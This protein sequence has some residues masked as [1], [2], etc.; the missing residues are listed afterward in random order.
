MLRYLRQLF[1]HSAVYGLSGVAGRFVALLVLPI[2]T[3]VLS[4]ADYGTIDILTTVGAFFGTVM[5][6]GMNASL[7]NF[8]YDSED[9]GFRKSV[10]TTNFVFVCA[11]GLALVLAALTFGRTIFPYVL[12]MELPYLWIVFALL[13]AF[14]TA[15]K[16]FFSNLFRLLLRPWSY[17]VIS[18]G[19]VAASYGAV[20]YLVVLRKEAVSGYLLG[21]L[22]GCTLMAVIPYFFVPDWFR[23]SVSWKV[24]KAMLVFGVPL[25][26]TDVALWA[27]T[28][29]ERLSVLRFQS[30]EQLGIYSVGTRIASV[31]ALGTFAF[32]LA[33]APLSLSIQKRPD[34]ER[35]Y[36]LVDRAYKAGASIAVVCLSALSL[37]LLRVMTPP[38]YHNGYLVVGYVAYGVFFAGIY[39]VS[40][41]GVAL[42][43]RTQYMTLAILCSAVVAIGLFEILPRRYGL[44]GTALAGCLGHI[45]GNLFVLYFGERVHKMGLSIRLTLGIV[46]WTLLAIWAQTAIYTYVADAAHQILLTFCVVTASLVVLIP[47]GIGMEGLQFAKGRIL[48]FLSR[49]ERAAVRGRADDN[50]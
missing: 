50:R 27:I 30:P 28:Y 47:A 14:W 32:R 33:W 3:S 7:V 18:L 25:M 40:G 37:P 39:W 9:V 24:L 22:I 23:G 26:P 41:L 2:L 34:A 29:F 48:Q 21:I 35:F 42:A 49:P 19:G 36:R 46:G 16:D 38:Q 4:P 11:W 43:K 1:S 5:S 10:V 13:A 17:L 12:R 45:S 31:I 6:L 8:Y 15:I 20:L 44:A